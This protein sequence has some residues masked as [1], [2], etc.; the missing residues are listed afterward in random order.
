MELKKKRLEGSDFAV[1]RSGEED[2]EEEDCYAS[3]LAHARTI[4]GT[5]SPYTGNA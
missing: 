1:S 4:L 5:R 3:M 2:R